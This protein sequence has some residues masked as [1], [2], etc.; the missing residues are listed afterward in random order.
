MEQGRLPRHTFQ[1][2]IIR[3]AGFGSGP[4]R[5]SVMFDKY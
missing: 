2:T 3:Q 1:L 5:D 4:E